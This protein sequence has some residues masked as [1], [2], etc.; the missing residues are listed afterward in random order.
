M[1]KITELNHVG[2]AVSN[3]EEGTS[4]FKE[5]FGLPPSDI[6]ES[7]SRGIRVGV[8]N[9]GNSI[10]EL[11]EPTDKNGSVAKFLEKQGHNAIHHLAFSVD[12]NLLDVAGDLKILGVEMISP[13]PTIG[14]LGHP[15]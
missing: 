6:I 15:I 5:K 13:K 14:I 1:F 4:L 9:V 3:L 8:I 12:R 2:I 7:E 11:I 10:L